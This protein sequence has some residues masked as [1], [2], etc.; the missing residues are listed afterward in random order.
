MNRRSKTLAVIGIFVIV[1][2]ILI[3]SIC[4]SDRTG[5]TTAAICFLLWAEVIFFVSGILVEIVADKG[6]P[7]ITRTAWYFIGSIYSGAVFLLSLANLANHSAQH[8]WFW[9]VQ[10]GLAAAA[11]AA[12]FLYS[13]ISKGIRGRNRKAE[14]DLASF[15]SMVTKLAVLS[16]RVADSEQAV[17]LKQLSEELRYTDATVVTD[18]D[19][20][21]RRAISVIER[22]IEKS[23]SD[24]DVISSNTKAIQ[25][26]VKERAIQSRSHK[27]GRV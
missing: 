15:E 26:A 6:E 20:A 3:L 11:L 1:A 17:L 16:E 10:I 13:S 9:A 24:L 14:N 7:I 2:S 27:R 8:H 5:L 21:I 4:I 22:E 23:E 12:L 19:A 25:S 18:S